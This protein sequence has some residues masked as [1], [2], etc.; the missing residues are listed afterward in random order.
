[1]R[2]VKT[3]CESNIKRYPILQA[4]QYILRALYSIVKSA[5]S[6]IVG[7]LKLEEETLR[8][9]TF[10]KRVQKRIC[11]LLEFFF[12]RGAGKTCEYFVILLHRHVIA[13]RD[14]PC[15]SPLAFKFDSARCEDLT[16]QV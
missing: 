2:T 5:T 7:N 15:I 6:W 10:A 9:N 16:F 1:M 11:F 12:S 8:R 13:P 4:K 14:T 3:S